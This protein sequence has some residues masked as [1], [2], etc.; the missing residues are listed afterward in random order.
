VWAERRIV[1]VKSGGTYSDHC[2]L[3]AKGFANSLTFVYRML[4][5]QKTSTKLLKYRGA[6]KSLARPT[7][8]RILFDGENI[9][10]DASLVIYI[11]LIFLQLLL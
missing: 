8:R 6:D 1:N 5:V 9:S 11:E 3:R 10:F 7:S 2:A 4:S